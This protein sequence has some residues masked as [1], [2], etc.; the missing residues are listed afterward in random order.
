MKK[1][2]LLSFILI[3]QLSFSQ[4]R[5]SKISDKNINIERA[6]TGKSFVE[7]FIEKCNNHDY[8]EFE[9][10]IISGGIKNG[11]DKNLKKGCEDMLEKYGKIEILNLNSVYFA[12][13]SKNLDPIDLVIYDIKTEK[14]TETKYASIWVYHD[15]NVIGGFRLSQ[16]KP[17]EKPKKSK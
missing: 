9:G 16:E 15:K 4:K 14:S 11:M 7:K 1:I 10:F 12:N 17:L 5:Y 6:E 2:A 3:C 8:S 13:F